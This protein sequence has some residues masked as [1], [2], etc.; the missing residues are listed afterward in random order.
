MRLLS[1]LHLFQPRLL[2]DFLQSIWHPWKC[3]LWRNCRIDCRNIYTRKTYMNHSR[4]YCILVLFL[5]GQYPFCDVH[6]RI[7][8]YLLRVFDWA[9]KNSFWF[10][11]LVILNTKSWK[12]Q[13]STDVFTF[14]GQKK[15]E[16]KLLT[17]LKSNHWLQS[18]APMKHKNRSWLQSMAITNLKVPV[19][20]N[21][22]LQR[23]SKAEIFSNQYLHQ[24]PKWLL[25][26]INTS[27]LFLIK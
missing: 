12:K 18:A 5:Q 25:I 9:R 16:S 26:V 19:D 15:L 8:L 23:T 1:Y 11:F 22:H 6:L 20:Y 4:S 24:A 17:A 27:F 13:Q 21:L 3:R 10:W 7:F 14:C 2:A